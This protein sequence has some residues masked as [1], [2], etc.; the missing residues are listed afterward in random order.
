MKL[1]KIESSNLFL[2]ESIALK[3]W[4][5]FNKILT[6]PYLLETTVQVNNLCEPLKKP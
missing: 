5:K 2:I 3:I 6:L 1:L 4:L